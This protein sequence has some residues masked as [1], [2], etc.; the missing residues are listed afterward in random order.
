MLTI[1]ARHLD[2]GKRDERGDICR[3]AIALQ[4]AQRALSGIFAIHSDNESDARL[5]ETALEISALLAPVEQL[6]LNSKI[7]TSED[8]EIRMAFWKLY[9]AIVPA[10]AKKIDELRGRYS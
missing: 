7:W 5:Y 1:A 2:G 9:D 3:S 4:F 10:C 8:L 6:G